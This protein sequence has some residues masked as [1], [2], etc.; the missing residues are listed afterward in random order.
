MA[1]ALHFKRKQ[2][3]TKSLTSWACESAEQ[4]RMWKLKRKI[5]EMRWR[6]TSMIP[7]LKPLIIFWIQEAI[8]SGIMSSTTSLTLWNKCQLWRSRGIEVIFLP[9]FHCDTVRYARRS[10]KFMDAYHQGLNGKEATWASK[11][12]RGHRVLPASLFDDL[13]KAC[14]RVWHSGTLA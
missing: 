1:N 8:P 3:Y 9:K 10:R 11:K 13:Q 2:A 6:D 7:L 4:V 5:L 14:V 12:Y